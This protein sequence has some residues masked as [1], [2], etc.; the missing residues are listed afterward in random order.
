MPEFDFIVLWQAGVYLGV[1]RD[2]TMVNTYP[3][4][5]TL[6]AIVQHFFDLAESNGC[7]H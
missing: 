7:R 3:D 1:V 2:A 6:G 4:A 5:V